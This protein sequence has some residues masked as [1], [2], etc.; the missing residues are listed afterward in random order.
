MN[1]NFNRLLSNSVVVFGGFFFV[2]EALA[3]S[4]WCLLDDPAEYRKLKKKAKG[5][6]FEC[7]SIDETQKLPE[8]LA[9]DLPCGRQMVFRKVVVPANS[10]LDHTE[11]SMGS[12][13]ASA[14]PGTNEDLISSLRKEYVSGSFSQGTGERDPLKKP[15][16]NKIQGRSFYIGKYEILSHHY[17][18]WKNGFF[19]KTGEELNA[20]CEKKQKSYKKTKVNKV[21]P[22]Q[23]ISWFDAVAFSRDY[24][25]WLLAQD[26]QRV[27]EGLH[28]SLPWEQGSTSYLRLPTESEW[29]FAARGGE[30]AESANS[31]VYAI[32]DKK[33]GIV[34]PG[35]AKEVA[36]YSGAGGKIHKKPKAAGLKAP[37]LFGVYDMVGNVDEIVFNMF[38]MVRPD[39]VHGQAGGFMVKGGNFSSREQRMKV[40]TRREVPFFQTF[41]EPKSKTTGFRLVISVPAFPFAANNKKRWGEG[42]TNTS[43]NKA[44][45]EAKAGLSVSDDA[46]R[47]EADSQ[48]D[49]LKEKLESGK[50]KQKDLLAKLEKIQVALEKSN[51]ELNEKARA[52]RKERYK[53]VIFASYNV[54]SMGRTALIG[55]LRILKWYEGLTPNERKAVGEILSKQLRKLDDIDVSLQK[56][57][58]FYISNLKKFSTEDRDNLAETIKSVKSELDFKVYEFHLE[59]ADKII[60]RLRKT[61]GVV[62]QKDLD[63]WIHDLDRSLKKRTAEKRKLEQ[64]R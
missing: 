24:T 1:K 54:A 34:R 51:V 17:D 3:D 36:I 49:D 16:F 61:G 20:A 10:L 58:N 22:A 8:Q 42:F 4:S 60:A 57:F 29:E 14:Q 33:K 15:E 63:I 21:L 30:V 27:K 40:G 45:E 50:L 7:P 41:G 32:R 28:P 37:N 62:K 13:T 12:F 47:N 52:E 56:A 26:R 11:I 25:N 55:Y 59:L 2:P 46:N 48:L 44:L 19:E 38:R 31:G 43:L 5:S 53:A 35:K 9:L 18:L 64:Y 39:R 23:N 6:T